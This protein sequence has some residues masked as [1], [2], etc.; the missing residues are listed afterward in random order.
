MYA[1]Q[2]YSHKL[3]DFC[4]SCHSADLPWAEWIAWQ[5][6]QNGNVTYIQAWDV[7]SKSD[8]AMKIQNAF[9]NAEHVIAILSPDF[10]KVRF[11]QDEWKATFQVDPNGAQ[12]L[13]LPIHIRECRNEIADVAASLVYIDLVGLDET[14][15]RAKLLEDIRFRHHH[16]IDPA[17]VHSR[18]QNASVVQ[19]R[20]P[21]VLPPI[22]INVPKRNPFFTGRVEILNH[23]HDML[24]RSGTMVQPQALSGLGGI[25]K[26]QIA[27]EFTYRYHSNYQAV[28]WVN[29]SSSRSLNIDFIDIANKIYTS[30][31]VQDESRALVKVKS[32]LEVNT[33]WLLILDDANDLALVTKYM[34][35][36]SLGK[37]HIVL[38]TCAQA[39]GR[40]A[41]RID[42]DKMGLEEGAL[43][44]LRRAHILTP[45]VPLKDISNTNDYLASRAISQSLDG[46]PLGLDQAGAY[47]EETSGS[48][49]RCLE[50]CHE[51]RERAK[52][53]KRPSRVVPDHPESITVT[54]IRPLI[55]VEQANPA[56]AELLRFCAFL[57]PDAI[58]EELIIKAGSEL[59]PILGP[60]ATD[61]F[62]LDAAVEELLKFSLVRRDPDKKTLNIHPLVQ[63]VVKDRMDE[64]TQREW[65]IRTVRAVNFALPSI[66]SATWQQYQQFFPHL[67]LCTSLIDEWE[68]EPV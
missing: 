32:W 54:W 53:L 55:A 59:G 33:H 63:D 38:T 50:L 31:N 11:S 23:L 14:E 51:Q 15:A 56:A 13:L 24:N 17:A 41:Q 8:L 7:Q 65:A 27:L 42:V 39:M 35:L 5:L 62:D 46:L 20:F 47:I 16:P 58:P 36:V 49:L 66:E 37:N 48:L 3:N 60:I 19:P 29:A 34:P 22:W 1:L 43:F 9:D 25:G 12:G 61:P 57:H 6:E 2:R 68:L 45:D 4:I 40:I 26:T 67:K 30:E 21:G 28:F 18:L 10:L 64:N 52:L 44:L